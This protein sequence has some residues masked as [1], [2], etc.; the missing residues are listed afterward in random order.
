MA[1]SFLFLE[2]SRLHRLPRRLFQAEMPEGVTG[3]E[4]LAGFA[5]ATALLH[6]TGIGTG[7]LLARMKAARLVGW[8]IASAG[9]GLA[10]GT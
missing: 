8:G 4:Y 9:I 10:L 5:S 3:F 1:S 6:G 2:Q 7:L